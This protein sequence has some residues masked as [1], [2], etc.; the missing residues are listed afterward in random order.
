MLPS[1]APAP[2]ETGGRFRTAAF[3]T[4]QSTTTTI[5][6]RWPLALLVTSGLRFTAWR[7]VRIAGKIAVFQ[8]AAP[9]HMGFIDDCRHSAPFSPRD[10]RSD[11]CLATSR[12]G[13]V[14]HDDT[15]LTGHNIP[16]CRS[17]ARL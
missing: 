9:R 8:P 15:L 5:P 10:Q 13:H 6:H 1:R 2:L 14:F 7:P 11:Y 16:T 4:V 17:G 12:D 3:P